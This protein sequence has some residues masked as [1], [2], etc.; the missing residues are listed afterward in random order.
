M[1]NFQNVCRNFGIDFLRRPN[2][3]GKYKKV[4]FDILLGRAKRAREKITLITCKKKTL[5]L[6]GAFIRTEI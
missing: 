4:A 3:G 6:S 5:L 1:K 2:Q